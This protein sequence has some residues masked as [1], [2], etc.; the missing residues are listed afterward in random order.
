ME[1]SVATASAGRAMMNGGDLSRR[2]SGRPSPKRGQV[3]MGIVVGLANSVAS[4]F[5]PHGSS[6]HRQ[7]SKSQLEACGEFTPSWRRFEGYLHLSLK[8]GGTEFIEKRTK[9]HMK[10]LVWVSRCVLS[11]VGL[12][13]SSLSSFG[14]VKGRAIMFTGKRKSRLGGRA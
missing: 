14:F 12:V 11:T 4:I 5:N 10:L 1:G 7:A 2:F 6:L 3:K 9:Q 8:F 13:A